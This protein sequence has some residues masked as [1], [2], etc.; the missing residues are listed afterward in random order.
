MQV[1]CLLPP[2]QSSICACKVVHT[3]QRIWIFASQDFLP[4]RQHLLL[5]ISCLYRPTEIP[6]CLREVAHGSQC[7][8]VVVAKYDRV[9]FNCFTLKALSTVGFAVRIQKTPH[10]E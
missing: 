9:Q 3:R 10:S 1:S 6:V 5:Q 8:R 4:C 2:A 7:T